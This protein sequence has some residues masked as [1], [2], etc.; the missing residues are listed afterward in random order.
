MVHTCTGK[1]KD[2]D[3][4]L[5]AHLSFYSAH[6]CVASEGTKH[7]AFEV[8]RPLCVCTCAPNAQSA[9]SIIGLRVKSEITSGVL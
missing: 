2:G 6:T 7:L 8:A 3:V 1:G 5:H 9:A 4:G